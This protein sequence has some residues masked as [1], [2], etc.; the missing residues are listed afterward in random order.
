VNR[1]HQA[2]I[3]CGRILCSLFLLALQDTD[4][5]QIQVVHSHPSFPSRNE[6]SVTSGRQ[7]HVNLYTSISAASRWDGPFSHYRYGHTSA[8]VPVKTVSW[9]VT[10]LTGGLFPTNER[11]T[12]V[13]RTGHWLGLFAFD[14][15]SSCTGVDC[16]YACRWNLDTDVDQARC[17]DLL[18][19]VIYCVYCLLCFLCVML[20]VF[21]ISGSFGRSHTIIILSFSISVWLTCCCSRVRMTF[22]SSQQF[23]GLFGR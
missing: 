17:K 11:D 1:H 10:I 16:G 15:L 13:C 18:C 4:W 7:R 19:V 21:N 2:A 9:C 20:C 22:G 6:N 14:G 8:T 23:H 12:A 5:K 3:R